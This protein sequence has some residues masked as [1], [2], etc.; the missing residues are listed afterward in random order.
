MRI[1]RID[2]DDPGDLLTQK[3]NLNSTV[4]SNRSQWDAIIESQQ[5]RP[6]WLTTYR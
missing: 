2:R 5:Q 1:K 4:I 6:I 3:I